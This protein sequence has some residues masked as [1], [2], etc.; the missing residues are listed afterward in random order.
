MGEKRR[1]PLTLN[2][3]PE[4]LNCLFSPLRGGGIAGHRRS[5]V[6]PRIS[7]A[8]WGEKSPF[9]YLRLRRKIVPAT[10]TSTS[11]SVAGS[12]ATVIVPES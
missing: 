9:G 12:G 1:C 7:F 5:F 2:L 11:A 6:G 10:P 4:T 8:P 3:K